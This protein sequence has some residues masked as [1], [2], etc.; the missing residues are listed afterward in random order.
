MRHL[1]ALANPEA[2]ATLNGLQGHDSIGSN[3]QVSNLFVLDYFESNLRRICWLAC[4]ALAVDV[5]DSRVKLV[6]SIA[7]Y[8]HLMSFV[9]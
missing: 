7:R 6:R 8:A 2:T 4:T 1:S 9:E 3:I 5:T